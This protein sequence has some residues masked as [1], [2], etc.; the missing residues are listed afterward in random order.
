MCTY[1]SGA[2]HHAPVSP[3]R[4]VYTFPVGDIFVIE[5]C[6]LQDGACPPPSTQRARTRNSDAVGTNGQSVTLRG[7]AS[8]RVLELG[9][10]VESHKDGV[11]RW[12]SA[13][14][15]GYIQSEARLEVFLEG[16]G[17]VFERWGDE[18]LARLVDCLGMARVENDA[19]EMAER[20]LAGLA[21][22]WGARNGDQAS[23]YCRV[24]KSAMFWGSVM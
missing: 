22:E 20:E 24:S 4:R 13:F 11:G 9:L 23:V 12:L 21:V 1:V 19:L 6:S 3:A 17:K 2:H 14:N 7:V 8:G 15:H 16:A 5:S 10:V 18:G